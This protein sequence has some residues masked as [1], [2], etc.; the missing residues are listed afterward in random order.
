MFYIHDDQVGT[1]NFVTD[2][3][4]VVSQF[5]LNLSFGETFV[6]QKDIWEH[7]CLYKFNAKELNSKTGLYYYG[8]RYFNPRLSFWYRV[9]SLVLKMPN[10]NP[11]VYTFDNLARFIDPDAISV[12]LEGN[13][14]KL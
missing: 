8:A 7:E 5:F 4:A 12:S 9:D 13:V 10:W 1:V 3:N 6:E 14:I 11:C 2:D